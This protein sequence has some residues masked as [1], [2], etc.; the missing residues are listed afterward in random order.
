MRHF[1]LFGRLIIFLMDPKEIVRSYIVQALHGCNALCCTNPECL[2]CPDFAHKDMNQK[3]LFKNATILAGNHISDPKLCQTINP[4]LVNPELKKLVENFPSLEALIK[5]EVVLKNFT[6][7]FDE[8]KTF[9]F[10]LINKKDAEPCK[11]MGLV[12]DDEYLKSY[13]MYLSEEK[14]LV[15]DLNEHLNTLALQLSTMDFETYYNLRAH[16][17]C[18]FFLS[19]Y[20]YSD[21]SKPLNELVSHLIKI[22]QKN[23]KIVFETLEQLP[24]VCNRVLNLIQENLTVNV[25]IN[26]NNLYDE[27][28]KCLTRFIQ[29][30]SK[31]IRNIP[32]SLF[33]NDILSEF[34]Y[35]KQNL[36]TELTFFLKNSK[37]FYFIS[38]PSIL[39]LTLKS[40]ILFE[41]LG[42]SQDNVA[43]IHIQR[44]LLEGR[45]A[46][47]RDV[48]LYLDVSRDNLIEDTLNQISRLSTDKL[49]LKLNV[50]FKGEQGV[51]AGGVS[52]EF[53]YLLCNNMFSPD[54][55]MFSKTCNGKYWFANGSD[56][57]VSPYYFSL[58]G[59]IVGLAIYNS[60]ILPIRFPIVLYKM[61]SHEP[62]YIEDYAEIDP[63]LVK[64]LLNTQKLIKDGSIDISE[65]EMTF[66]VTKEVFG[67]IKEIPLIENGEN[68]LV[69]N[70][71]YDE[72]IE[73]Y[74]NY[75]LNKSINIQFQNFL[76]GYERVCSLKEGNMFKIFKSDELDI[77]VSG[78]EIVDWSLL[79]AN[80]KYTDGYDEKSQAI[81][82]FWEIFDELNETQKQQF[83]RFSTGSD[84]IPI[85][86]IKD[87]QLVIQ[88]TNDIAKLPVSHTCFNI[89][90]LPNY[91]SKELMKEKIL[92]SISNTEGFGLI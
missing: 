30:F 90:A 32:S 21:C 83:F 69:T 74:T 85:S 16:I 47:Q 12:L 77:L 15:N 63:E 92:I 10:V 43:R 81:I 26:K 84:R 54:Y 24:F 27:S 58:F 3:E 5:K 8:P 62:V 52:R 1:S 55:G 46:T 7:V 51:D 64:N 75:L 13:F 23:V 11:E 35:T 80:T 36:E 45:P 53:F 79:K 48:Q 76:K 33:S 59:T 18:L 72:F 89:F 19:L 2:S 50:V 67:S 6:D 9:G 78:E 14:D 82:W 61:I 44:A 38:Y 31:N 71:N 4:I 20:N 57:T 17:L 70:E 88:K 87:F 49:T 25:I 73:S 42:Y 66:T 39:N 29:D 65:A 34:L 22:Y 28:I 41:F 56:I 68:I 91:S 60:I 37:E 40:R 86:G